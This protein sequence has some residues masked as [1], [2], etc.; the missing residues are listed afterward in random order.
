LPNKEAE[1]YRVLEEIQ[2]YEGEGTDAWMYAD[3]GF[4]YKMNSVMRDYIL[5]KTDPEKTASASSEYFVTKDMII[6]SHQEKEFIM[7]YRVTED[8]TWTNFKKRL[9]AEKENHT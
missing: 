9:E 3:E 7:I 5:L 6:Q 2:D 1:I 8:F 4:S